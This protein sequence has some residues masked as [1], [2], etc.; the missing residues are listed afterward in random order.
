MKLIVNEM[1]KTARECLFSANGTGKH[2]CRHDAKLCPIE[3]GGEC[4]HLMAITSPEPVELHPETV[5]QAVAEST[6]SKKRTTKRAAV[7]KAE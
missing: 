1:P 4:S 3:R 6:E 5:L 2:R 7:K